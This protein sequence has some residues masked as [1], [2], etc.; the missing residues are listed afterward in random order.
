M[1][2]TIYCTYL[3]VY[4]G[5]KLP[6]LYIGSTSVDKINK[7]YR[8]SV[9]SKK[10]RE[11]WKCELKE[12]PHLFETQILTTHS[13]RE[14][15][16]EEE[17]CYQLE[18]DVVRS[19][20]YINMAIANKKFIFCDYTD[21]KYKKKLSIAQKNRFESAGERKKTSEANKKRFLN[22][23]E[24][25]KISEAQ[26]KKYENGFNNPFLGK[27]HSLETKEKM[28]LAGKQRIGSKNSSYGRKWFYNPETLEN[29]KC[30]PEDKPEN[31]IPG[32]KI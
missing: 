5:D 16:L 31:Y 22:S 18:H 10:Y 14:E 30:L 9:S 20:E 15:A 26:K 13:T 1:S 29:I 32:R 25:K 17:M 8:G 28:S 27:S 21:V 2:N 4:S 12:N 3:T 6:P 23:E 7:G 11:I 19:P 24:R